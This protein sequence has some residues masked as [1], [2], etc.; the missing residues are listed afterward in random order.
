MKELQELTAQGWTV[1]Y[2]YGLANWVRGWMQAA[3]GVWYGVWFK[4]TTTIV[5][6]HIPDY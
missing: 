3:Y 5:Y 1:A 6:W 2:T 4:G